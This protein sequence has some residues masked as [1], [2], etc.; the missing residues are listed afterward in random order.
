MFSDDFELVIMMNEFNEPNA[1]RESIKY[2]L[3]DL[4]SEGIETS[5]AL[6]EIRGYGFGADALALFIGFGLGLFFA[7]KKIEENLDSWIRLG[8]RLSKAISRLKK[9]QANVML[10][11][12]MA[13]ALSM[14]SVADIEANYSHILPLSSVI[15][16]IPNST[17]NRE[18][19][20]IFKENPYRYYVFGWSINNEFIRI[21]YMTSYGEIIL[22][23]KLPLDYP[24]FH[25]I[26][27]SDLPQKT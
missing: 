18:L 9:R 20:N 5:D 24:E 26:A 17:L 22:T 27:F 3:G 13:A 21:I 15:Y 14:S 19:I 11:E 1:H 4:S 16:P 8:K 7:G 25:K 2:V 10:S 12:P 6:A 23:H